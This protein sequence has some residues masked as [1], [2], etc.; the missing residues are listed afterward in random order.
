MAR[1]PNTAIVLQPTNSAIIT[2]DLCLQLGGPSA[3]LWR[4]SV[5][6]DE[7]EAA[8]RAIERLRILIAQSAGDKKSKKTSREE[9]LKNCQPIEVL[10]V[11]SEG[12]QILNE[13][14]GLTKLDTSVSNK[15]F[16][17]NVRQMLIG[18]TVV[19]VKYNVPTIT[20]VVPPSALYVGAPAVCAGIT[21]LFTTEVDVQ[22][23]W[24]ARAAPK[25][26]AGTGA[27][28]DATVRVIST[29]PVFTPTTRELGESLFLRV[30]PE[31]GSD[32]CTQVEL[33]QVRAE[34]P[35]MD[36]WTQTKQSVEAPSFRMVTYNVLHEEFCSTSS[37]K[38]TIYPFA[39]DD[40]LSLEYRQSRIVQELLAYNGDIICLQECGKKV[41]QQFFSRV[42]TQ[43]GYEGCYTNKNGGVREG[44][45]CFWRRS[46]FFLQEK[47]EFP[48]NWS[49]MEKEH[50]ALA[51]EVTRHPEL[52]EA[53]ENVTSIG[54]LVLLKDNATNEE[55][56][57][58]NTHLFYHANA[59]HIRLL[60]VYMLLHKLKSRSDS[61]RGVVLCGDFNFTHTTG[62][63]K[64]VT[65]GRTEASHHSWAKGEVFHWGCDRMLGINAAEGAGGSAEVETGLDVR[66]GKG[67]S[68]TCASKNNKNDT[69]NN[70]E[71]NG[72]SVDASTSCAAT[73]ADT[74]VASSVKADYRPP[75][76][77]FRADMEAPMQ[78]TDAYGVTDPEMPWT[79][80]TMTFREVIDYVFFNPDRL[81]VVQTIPIPPE[82][83]LS[84]NVAL[85]N[86]KYPS[87]HVAL[88]ADLS[89][90]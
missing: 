64:L 29:K 65:T 31:P 80:Y 88:I 38:K 73:S 30:L 43:Y 60:Q 36:R 8:D 48:L 54:A 40:I 61:R 53:L 28:S 79:N 23:E 26:P 70:N 52:K 57:V 17:R 21:A 51:A 78:F 68:A 50:P 25:S 32:L 72:N 6:R 84:E 66:R 81:L 90:K 63:Y 75:F 67:E 12:E 56:V 86:R 24:C 39:T 22:Y 16:W 85:P 55:L 87:D 34:V 10:G 13:E 27:S 76:D 58:G 42:M 82:S 59:C 74:G 15:E 41:Y 69:N 62:G 44:C 9:I 7:N 49:T 83:E 46:R 45:A 33:P 3:P 5:A 71:S 1:H 35:P 37:A 77:V 2:L 47:D 18:S 14:N 19:P 11:S 4:K 89:Y 20:A